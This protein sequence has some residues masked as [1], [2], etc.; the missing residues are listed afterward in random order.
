[1][2]KIEQKAVLDESGVSLRDDLAGGAE[3]KIEPR[4]LREFCGKTNKDL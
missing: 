1:M 2:S 3:K 4:G